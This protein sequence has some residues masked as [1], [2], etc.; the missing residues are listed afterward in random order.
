MQQRCGVPIPAAILDQGA[1]LQAPELCES[2]EAAALIG[3][4][5]GAWTQQ[6][7]SK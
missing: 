4:F 5:D 3:L 2:G 1:Q 7:E 6:Q